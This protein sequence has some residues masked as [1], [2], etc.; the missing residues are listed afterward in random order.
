MKQSITQT[1]INRRR[2]GWLTSALLMIL[3]LSAINKSFAQIYANS[4]ARSGT[5]DCN[6]VTGCGNSSVTAAGSARDGSDSDASIA[7]LFSRKTVLELG[8]AGSAFIVLRFPDSQLPTP[9]KTVYVKVDLPQVTGLVTGVLGVVGLFENNRITAQLLTGATNNAN[10]TPVATGTT[11]LVTDATGTNY[12][13]AVT[14]ASNSSSFN[15][16]RINVDAQ[17]LDIVSTLTLNVYNA[18]YYQDG[19]EDACTRPAFASLG[20]VSGTLNVS[21]GNVVSSSQNAIDNSLITSSTIGGGG[22]NIGALSSLSQTIYYKKSSPATERAVVYLSFP[23]SLVDVNLL[24]G[25]SLQAFSGDESAGP[26]SGLGSLLSANV[27]SLITV[28]GIGPNTVIPFYYTPSSSFD[29][30]RIS[31]NN[32]VDASVLGSS[33]IQVFGAGVVPQKP[34]LSQS[35]VYQFEGATPNVTA[36]ASNGGAIFWEGALPARTRLSDTPGAAFPVPVNANGSFVAVAAQGAG[37][38]YTSDSTRLTV[39]VLRDVSTTIPTGVGSEA[40]PN[41]AAIVATSVGNTVSYAAAT[42]LPAGITFNTTTGALTASG[43]LPD[44]AVT[45][46]YNVEVGLFV[47][48]QPTGLTLTKTITI[49]PLLRIPGGVFPFVST[50]ETTYARNISESLNDNGN[51]SAS[52]GKTGSTLKYSLNPPTARVAAAP[53]TFT[54][55]EDGVLSGN[56]QAAGEGTY[57]FTIYVTDDEQVRQA[58]YIL[59]ITTPLP[60]TLASFNAAAEG[61]TASLSWSTSEESNSDR[62]DVERSQNGKVWSK[63]G[64][65]KSGQESRNVK[66]YNFSDN[67]P[68]GGINYYRLKMVD[69]DE[70]FTYSQIKEVKFGTTAFVSPNPVRSGEALKITLADWS[71]VKQVQV[72]NANGKTVFESA[73]AFSADISTTNLS[74]GSYIVKVIQ[75]DGNVST[76]RF[77]KQ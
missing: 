47:N 64:S 74:A 21:L 10:G 49:D 4:D 70:T 22:V 7:T 43:T 57:E 50:N 53:G 46:F 11:R 6:G 38:L 34:T 1:L 40:F 60:V 16:V 52:G 28:N 48:G 20:E 54:I 12:Y 71:K 76:H 39:I 27:L 62:F 59:R 17:P 13:I 69:L 18:F 55:S 30:I 35:L 58:Q 19:V 44:V 36:T 73:N 9:G 2:V 56:P 5:Y 66:Y 8:G 42:G 37:C 65:V 75:I 15:A 25:I 23:R 14:P 41:G 68:A 63:I 29:R 31:L 77:V 32:T 51:G 61:T 45:T 33:G 72:I 67:M 26:E 24:Q 3:S